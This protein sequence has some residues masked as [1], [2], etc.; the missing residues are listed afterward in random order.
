MFQKH[1]LLKILRNTFSHE[2]EFNLQYKTLS[3]QHLYENSLN[4]V[5]IHSNKCTLD[6]M[7]LYDCE[8]SKR[9]RLVKGTPCNIRAH[10]VHSYLLVVSHEQDGTS[11]VPAAASL[12]ESFK[13]YQKRVIKRI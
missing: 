12:A 4:I 7:F 3:K 8:A 10:V 5:K 11:A 1:V 6:V 9:F 2:I 13:L